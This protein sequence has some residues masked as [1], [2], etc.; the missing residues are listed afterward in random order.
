VED[1]I[2]NCRYGED[3]TG[4]YYYSCN[5]EEAEWNSEWGNLD[6]GTVSVYFD[7]SP[8]G[9]YV[10]EFVYSYDDDYNTTSTMSV[11]S[12]ED[13]SLSML[14]SD[15]AVTTS[16]IWMNDDYYYYEPESDSEGNLCCYSNG[17]AS[18]VLKNIS[19]AQVKHYV[20][21]GTYSAYADYD[22]SSGG[23]LKIFNE[24]GEST[25]I[26]SDVSSYCYIS[27][28]LIVYLR[29]GKLYVYRGEDK[30]KFKIDSSVTS[31]TCDEA[32]YEYLL[33]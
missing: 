33:Y 18:T 26:D 14:D 32:D 12:L 21:N 25:K 10:M 28:D 15:I 27:D 6:D 13:G 19:N 5:G 22:Y 4:G 16:G 31:F 20:A 23:T 8:S 7:A 24:D 29:D 17:T 3:A 9:K 2:Y 30:E 11:L 1:Y